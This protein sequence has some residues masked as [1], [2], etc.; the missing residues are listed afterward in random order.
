[1]YEGV[2]GVSDK[3]EVISVGG[4]QSSVQSEREF[5]PEPDCYNLART[6]TGSTS[7]KAGR[8]YGFGRI[9]NRI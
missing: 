3:H 8:I 1:M 9:L 2:S 7:S 5:W 6:G 4:V